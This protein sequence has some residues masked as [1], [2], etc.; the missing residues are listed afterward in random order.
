MAGSETEIVQKEMQIARMDCDQL[1]RE[2]SH[3]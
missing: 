2:F 3:I 1:N